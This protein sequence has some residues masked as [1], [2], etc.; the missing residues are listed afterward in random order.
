LDLYV[1]YPKYVIP[2]NLFI[3][4]CPRIFFFLPVESQEMWEAINREYFYEGKDLVKL[5]RYKDAFWLNRDPYQTYH[6]INR[7]DAEQLFI[8]DIEC[9][10]EYS[11]ARFPFFKELPPPL[12]ALPEFPDC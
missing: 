4:A 10:L 11:P 12:T 3:E 2:A 8:T 5:A 7:T 1:Y 6:L 9:D